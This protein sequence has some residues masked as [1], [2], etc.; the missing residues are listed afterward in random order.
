[1]STM[2]SE[3]TSTTLAVITKYTFFVDVTSEIDA[4]LYTLQ[5]EYSTSIT[6]KRERGLGVITKYTLFVDVTSEIDTFLCTL[7]TE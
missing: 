7:Q 5:T 1:M 3:L 4:F 6:Y 2:S